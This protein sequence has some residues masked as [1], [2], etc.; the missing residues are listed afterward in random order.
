MTAALGKRESSTAFCFVFF[1]ILSYINI[2]KGAKIT[3]NFK[4]I[5]SKIKGIY[6]RNLAPGREGRIGKKREVKY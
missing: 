3:S 6:K 1:K 2:T 4:R 5:L